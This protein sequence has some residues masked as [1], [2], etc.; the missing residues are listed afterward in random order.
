MTPRSATATLNPTT[1]KIT[2]T[3]LS[4]GQFQSSDYNR[5]KREII[6][7]PSKLTWSS[8]ASSSILNAVS[9][10]LLLWSYNWPTSSSIP[11][12]LNE[13]TLARSNTLMNLVVY[14]LPLWKEKIKIILKCE[15]FF[16]NFSM[17]MTKCF[18]F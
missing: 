9:A 12:L 16:F 3:P 11:Q 14:T 2:N 13:C 10:T 6:L 4:F 8:Q 17:K 15:H 5:V 18:F 7:L 1:L